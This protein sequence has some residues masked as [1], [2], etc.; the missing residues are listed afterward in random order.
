MNHENNPWEINPIWGIAKKIRC[1]PPTTNAGLLNSII[2]LVGIR[3]RDRYPLEMVAYGLVLFPLVLHL[4]D[5]Y[6]D[7]MH[8]QS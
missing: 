3:T 4:K 1:G 2:P 7:T 5:E 8:T 6:P